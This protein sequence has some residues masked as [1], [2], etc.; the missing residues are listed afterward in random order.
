[1][2]I[3]ATKLR[4]KTG[5]QGAWR[6]VSFE[7]DDARV[8][9]LQGVSGE[10]VGG[11]LNALMAQRAAAKGDQGASGQGDAV[12]YVSGE[13]GGRYEGLS[14]ERM[15]GYAAELGLREEPV[16][17]RGERVEAMLT[18]LGLSA[19]RARRLGELDPLARWKVEV[20]EC[21]LLG[22]RDWVV[23][24]EGDEGARKAKFEVLKALGRGGA[25]LVI[26]SSAK[27]LEGLE[28][29]GGEAEGTDAAGE[30]AR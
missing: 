8:C 14:V 6:E 28:V 11:V 26:S 29:V 20:G 1:M 25:V 21:A 30:V 7:V 27:G 17:A 12:G 16:Q 3:R 15:L 22:A 13:V 10:A 4:V 9:L 19:V 24:I 5:A 18:T 2:V 23:V